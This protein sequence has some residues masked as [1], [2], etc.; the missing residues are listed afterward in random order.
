MRLFADRPEAHGA[1]GEA[2]DD[3]LGRFHVFKRNRR[4]SILELEQP[5]QRAEMAILIV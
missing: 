1:G 3:L 4:L 2:L 5:A